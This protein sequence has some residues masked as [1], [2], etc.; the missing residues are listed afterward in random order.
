[1]NNSKI[2]THGMS[3]ILKLVWKE[4][5]I[6]VILVIAGIFG[7]AFATVQGSLFLEALI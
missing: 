3:R 1:M 4:Y 2:D 7:A 5:K 6:A